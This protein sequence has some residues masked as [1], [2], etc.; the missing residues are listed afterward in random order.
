MSATTNTNARRL[1]IV[2]VDVG[3]TLG[4]SAVCIDLHLRN[5][6]DR[7]QHELLFYSKPQEREL[8]CGKR[9]V[10]RDL[11]LQTQN[12]GGRSSGLRRIVNGMPVIGPAA[13]AVR[14]FLDYLGAIPTVIRLARLFRKGNYDLVHCNNTFTYQPEAILGAWLSGKPLVVH[15]RTPGELSWF[16]RWLARR[17]AAIVAINRN[18]ARH[19]AHQGLTRN[20]IVCNDPC[21]RPK[22]EHSEGLRH[23]LLKD[24]GNLI[25]GTVSRLEPNKGIDTLLRAAKL[26][27]G[28]HPEVQYV[29]VGS[30]SQR[31]ALQTLASNLGLR[32][33]VRFLG[34]VPNAFDYLA[35]MDV[36]VCTSHVEG[37]PL[38]VL[39]AMLLGV[40][41]VT[42]DVGM[43][44]EWI[45][46]PEHGTIIPAGSSPSVLADSINALLLDEQRRFQMANT[47]RML[48]VGYC[49][50]LRSAAELDAILES[51]LGTRVVGGRSEEEG[52]KILGAGIE[53]RWQLHR[54]R[55]GVEHYASRIR[56]LMSHLKSII[57]RRSSIEASTN[58]PLARRLR[59]LSNIRKN[60]LPKWLERIELLDELVFDPVTQKKLNTLQEILWCWRV[61]RRSR[62]YDVVVMG[63]DRISRV[64]AILQ[65]FLRRKR[66]PH[67]YIAWLCSPTGGWL[68]RWLKRI[69]LRW[70]IL[71]CSCAIVQGRLEIGAQASYLGV[72]PS[73]FV[74]LPYHP[75]LYDAPYRVE[76]GDYIFAGGDGNR[77]YRTLIEA[78][79]GLPY[80]VVIAA[81]MRNHFQGIDIPENVAIVTL[82]KID[83]IQKMAGAAL[84]VVP[85]HGGLLHP[86]GQQTW[87]NGMELGKP[88]I[89]AEDRSASDYITH[90]SDGWLV[91]PGNCAQLRE[92]VCLLMED[93]VLA[94]KLGERARESARRF[95]PENYVDEVYALVQKQVESQRSYTRSKASPC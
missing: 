22:A 75:T 25:V 70:A 40:P 82:S 49:D 65:L 67:I 87:L 57:E 3:G 6:D 27:Q 55:W 4:G 23:L 88:V 61:F 8:E 32:D 81:L 17:A 28:S 36:F 90:T 24:R 45:Q 11:G 30:G 80:R 43:V 63:S 18:V 16:E 78:V 85:M 47:S 95:S 91:E 84:I 52:G 42:T 5:C 34:F 14:S 58:E 48:A 50:P 68:A 10:I 53:G 29:I 74:F 37:G 79:R 33:S 21:E 94:H 20:V 26:L 59:I 2:H 89:V 66:V 13:S 76:E 44:D 41:V 62:N 93:R 56:I 9:H 69:H 73:K 19:L 71:G 15:Y 39:E 35:C 51:V 54:F 38:T 64:F 92:A 86:G 31:E 46:A 83:Y 60:N 1:K 77:D 72:A 7:F 12:S